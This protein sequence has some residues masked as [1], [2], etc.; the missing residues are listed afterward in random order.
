M[1][2]SIVA[3]GAS[4]FADLEER[5]VRSPPRVGGTRTLV[6][7]TVSVVSL[8]I[9]A[10]ALARAASLLS[11]PPFPILTFGILIMGTIFI[12]FVFTARVTCARPNT[13][14]RHG[15]SL[16]RKALAGALYCAAALLLQGRT[17][18]L[19]LSGHCSFA[20]AAGVTAALFYP[21]LSR[22]SA[23]LR[24][25]FRADAVNKSVAVKVAVL[26]VYIGAHTQWAWA[27]RN[28]WGLV[29]I[30]LFAVLVTCVSYAVRERYY[31]HLHH[32]AL[33]L[34]LLPMSACSSDAASAFL[35]A[36]CIATFAEGS[37]NWGAA[38]LWHRRPDPLHQRTSPRPRT[39]RAQ[40]QKR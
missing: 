9:S 14:S 30:S 19:V 5:R 37:V 32:W 22:N 23:A 38:P 15:T 13:L 7:L 27:T 39:Y 35:A 8:F 34:A 10:Y 33:A 36:F 24:A 29:I 17:P 2:E 31:L 25:S 40:S 20:Y 1:L 11:P 6:Y 3:R 16:T 21:F 12:S 18:A 28:Y 4:R 26:C